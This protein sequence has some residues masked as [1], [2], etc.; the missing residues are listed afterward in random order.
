[1]IWLKDAVAAVFVANSSNTRAAPEN[2]GA[3]AERFLF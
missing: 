3:R 1:M 2:T